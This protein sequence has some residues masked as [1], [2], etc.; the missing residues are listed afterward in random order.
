MAPKIGERISPK[1]NIILT[2]PPPKV[3]FLKRKFP[4]NIIKSIKRNKKN[5]YKS[6]D[7]NLEKPYC[8]KIKIK[9]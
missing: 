9:K 4:N 6:D 7:K 3:S 1:I 5:P 2:S 8:K